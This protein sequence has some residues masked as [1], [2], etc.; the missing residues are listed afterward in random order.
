MGNSVYFRQ[1]GVRLFAL[2]E[3]GRRVAQSP[4]KPALVMLADGEDEVA[5]LSY[6]ELDERSR[7]FARYLQEQHLSGERVLIMLP[8]GVEYVIAFIGCLYAGAIAVPVFPPSGSRNGERVNSVVADCQPALAVVTARQEAAIR[9]QLPESC[10]TLVPT[11][12]LAEG[13][14]PLRPVAPAAD[15][16]AYLQY[17]S[18]S[19]STLGV[20]VTQDALAQQMR[21]LARAWRLSNDE[22]VVS[23]LPM[24][25]DFGLVAATMYSLVSGATNVMMAPVAFVQHPFR[26]LDAI[27]RYRAAVTFGPNFALDMSCDRVDDDALQTLDL[28]SLRL[29]VVGA[30]PVRPAP[31]AASPRGSAR[32]VPRRQLQHRVRPGRGDPRCRALAGGAGADGHRFDPVELG[33]GRLVEV[34]DAG[35]AGSCPTTATGCS[36]PSC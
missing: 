22:V 32:R 18:G 6:T 23:W 19:T 11:D 8:Q 27:S 35:E 16:V 34:P 13:L 21:L 3:I 36:T 30:E 14:P 5:R 20:M 1:S 25:H 24:F 31:C 26:W 10:R 9:R 15:D 17:T 29:L 12:V 2:A 33:R 4:D 28:T 7:D